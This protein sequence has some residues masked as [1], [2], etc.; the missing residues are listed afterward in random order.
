MSYSE[1]AQWQP[2]DPIDS[3]PPGLIREARNWVE[4]CTWREEPEDLEEYP[5]ET[6]TRGVNRHYDGGWEMDELERDQ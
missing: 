1:A 2:G 3:L 5:D 6:I 4:D